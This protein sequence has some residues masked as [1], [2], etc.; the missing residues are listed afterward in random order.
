VR[1]IAAT[2]QDLK[3]WIEEGKF[4][5]D[6]FYRLNV[7]SLE[8][9]PLRNRKDDIP[10]LITHFLEKYC[11]RMG[12]KMKRIPPKVMKIFESYSWPGNV[13]ELENTIERIIAIED[14]ETITESSLPEEMLT[15][16]SESERNYELKSG[17]DLN[18]TI[19]EISRNF[20]QQALRRANGNLKETAELLGINYR[21]LRYLIEKLELK[22]VRETERR[23][24]R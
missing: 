10:A 21:S 14:R 13:R 9:P 8:V 3:R 15:P 20:V 17:F 22:S 6:L 16:Q 5:E 4:R 11:A 19:D 12:R 7:I 23:L 2:N 1:I 24:S 18:T